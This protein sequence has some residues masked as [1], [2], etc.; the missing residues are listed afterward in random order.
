M[1]RLFQ[2]LTLVHRVH[3]IN[4]SYGWVFLPF[5]LGYF[6]S[7][8]ERGHGWAW[9]FVRPKHFHNCTWTGIY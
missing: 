6:P 2:L 4:F 8:R 5:M 7:Y 3:H 9:Q 1:K